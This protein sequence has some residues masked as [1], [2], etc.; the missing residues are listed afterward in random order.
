MSLSQN[1]LPIDVISIQSEVVYGHVGNNAV[2]PVLQHHG[3][4]TATIPTVYYSNTPL[5]LV[6]TVGLFQMIGSAAF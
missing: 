3:F 4:T 6:Y 2:I 1:P 5:Y